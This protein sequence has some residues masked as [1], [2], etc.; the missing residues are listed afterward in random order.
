MENY[1]LIFHEKPIAL[2]N[3]RESY[4]GQ[5]QKQIPLKVLHCGRI[6]QAIDE[7]EKIIVIQPP[8]KNEQ[9]HEVFSPTRNL[10]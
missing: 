6:L 4:R 3:Y 2:S 1:F 8:F 5:S 10:R 7:K 9:N